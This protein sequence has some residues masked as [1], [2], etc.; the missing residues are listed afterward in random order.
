MEAGGH[1]FDA[2]FSELFAPLAATAA[3]SNPPPELRIT[4]QRQDGSQFLALFYER[5]NE[6]LSVRLPYQITSS[7]PLGRMYLATLENSPPI[8]GWFQFA[9]Q[10]ATLRSVGN[11]TN[12]GVVYYHYTPDPLTALIPA[13]DREQMRGVRDLRARLV[14]QGPDAN[15]SAVADLELSVRSHMTKGANIP[16]HD[17]LRIGDVAAPSIQQAPAI[18]RL[19]APLPLPLSTP[20]APALQQITVVGDLRLRNALMLEQQGPAL[21]IAPSFV[22]NSEQQQI[23]QQVVEYFQQT[24]RPC[25]LIRPS[26]SRPNTF[27]LAYIDPRPSPGYAERQIEV[28]IIGDSNQV[29]LIRLVVEPGAA[30]PLA[31]NF[32]ELMQRFFPYIQVAVPVGYRTDVPIV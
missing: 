21:Q 7:W 12:S 6:G 16:Q 5:L 18:N 26:G 2:I 29:A 13:F 22:R 32:V 25:F 8:Q 3:A 17:G 19:I 27:V 20:A 14:F 9:A 4:L 28:S 24:G 11:S 30:S 10:A 23:K 31:R 15:A 1:D